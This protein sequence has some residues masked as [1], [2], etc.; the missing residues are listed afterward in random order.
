[1]SKKLQDLEASF[2][3]IQKIV[4]QMEHGQLSLQTSLEL[5]EKGIALTRECQKM[6]T[7]TEQKIEILLAQ[8]NEAQLAPFDTNSIN[9]S[10]DSSDS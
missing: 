6:L 4:E 7:E 10:S 3:E 8:N 5:F 9:A 2:D 1:M